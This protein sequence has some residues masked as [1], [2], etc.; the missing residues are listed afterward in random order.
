MNNKTFT[1]IS[2]SVIAVLLI[3]VLAVAMSS[4]L[5]A[6]Q[7]SVVSAATE[8]TLMYA[9]YNGTN[10][11]ITDDAAVDGHYTK[12]QLAA[13]LGLS[14]PN[15]LLAITSGQMLYDYLNNSG[16]YSSYQYA[17]LANDV[18][19]AF[20]NITKSGYDKVSAHSSGALFTKYLDGNGYKVSIEAGSGNGSYYT[21][22]ENPGNTN[23]DDSRSGTYA[24]T[25]YLCAVNQGTIKNLTID[26]TSNHIIT[27]SASNPNALYVP[28]NAKVV[29]GAGV[30][31]GL[32]KGTIDNIRLN[33]NSVF[34]LYMKPGGDR[35]LFENTS[36]IGGFAG[37]MTAGIISNSQ[38]DIATDGGVSVFVEGQQTGLF[39]D[40]NTGSVAGG[41]IG[42]LQ[43]GDAKVE[44]CALT[45]S[46]RIYACSNTS[47]VTKMSFAA[48]AIATSNNIAGHVIFSGEIKESEASNYLEIQENGKVNEGQIKGI[49]SSWTGTREDNWGDN[50]KSV[51]GLLFDA[52]GKNVQS[53][54]VLYNLNL[55]TK[56]NGGT[57]YSTLDSSKDIDNWTEIYP[58]S[59]GGS[60]SVRYDD[61]T[62]L[63]DIRIEAVADGHDGEKEAI[64]DF[65]MSTTGT[66]YHK[67]FMPEGSTGKII[68]SGVFDKNGSLTNHINMD[69]DKPIYAEIYMLKSTDYGKFNYTFGTMG[70]ITYTDNGNYVN[71]KNTKGY[72][73][74]GGALSFPTANFV[75]GDKQPT[76][77]YTWEVYRDGY[78]TDIAQSY[79]PGTYSMRTAV[80]LGTNTYGYYSEADRMIAWQAK[81]DYTFTI[82]QGVFSY[83]EA[84][85]SSSTGWEKEF[86]FTLKM[87][88]ANDFDMMRYQQNGV[89]ASEQIEVPDTDNSATF[90]T[91]QG[92]GKNGMQY[93]FYAYKFDEILQD[94]VVV[95]VSSSKTVKIDNEAPEIYDVR[96]FTE[97]AE[98]VRTEVTEAVLNSWQ[99]EKVIV[100]FT[101]TENGKSGLQTVASDG[102]TYISNEIVDE[103]NMY[104]VTLTL[105]DD[106]AHSLTY[107]DVVGNSTTFDIKAL[108]DLNAGSLDVRASGYSPYYG[109]YDPDGFNLMNSAQIGNSGWTLYVSDSVDG[110]GNPVWKEMGAVVNGDFINTVDW[111]IGDYDTYSPAD[112]RVK[113][114]ND[115]GLYEDVYAN[116]TAD[117]LVGQFCVY[118]KM[119]DFYV[120]VSLEAITDKDGNSLKDI[121]A[122]DPD[123]FNKVYDSTQ[124]YKGPELEIDISKS[125]VIM[126]NTDAYN[127]T[128]VIPEFSAIKLVLEYE[129]ASIGSTNIRM[130]AVLEGDDDYKFDVWFA[131]LSGDYQKNAEA[132]NKVAANITKLSVT[133]NLE[134]YLNAQYFY[135]DDIPAY[136]DANITADEVARIDLTTNAKKGASVGTYAVEGKLHTANDSIDVTI[137]KSSIQIVPLPVFVDLRYDGST[138][139]PT[140]IQFDGLTHEITATYKDAITGETKKATVDYTFVEDDK[141][142]SGFTKIGKFN[143]KISTGDGNYVVDGMDTFEMTVTKGFVNIEMKVVN[144]D[145][146]GNNNT[147]DLGLTEEQKKYFAEGDITINYYKYNDGAYYDSVEKVM[148]GSYDLNPTT[149]TSQRGYY[150][151]EVVVR[152]NDYFLGQTYGKDAGEL[153]LIIVNIAKT[154]ITGE[155]V[156]YNYDEQKHT[157]DVVKGKIEVKATAD[158]SVLW[159]SSMS[160]EGAIVVKYYDDATKSYVEVDKSEDKL[161]GWF[162]DVNE[163]GY[164]FRVE[165]VGTENYAS[166]SIDVTMVIDKAAFQNVT[167]AGVSGVY[168][169]QAYKITEV[170]PD[171]YKTSSTISYY[172]N[173]RAYNSLDDI[174]ALGACVNVGNYKIT[175]RMSK[176]NYVP[177][178]IEATVSIA[179]AKLN[180]SANALVATYDGTAHYL[181][182]NG[183]EFRDGNYYYMDHGKEVNALI[184]GTVSATDAGVYGGNITVFVNN[185]EAFDLQ[186]YIEIYPMALTA[187]SASI[188]LPNK[189]PSGVSVSN[190]YG[191]YTIDGVEKT[192]DLLYYTKSAETGNLTLVKPDKDGVLPDGVY[193]VYIEVDNNHYLQNTWELKVGQINDR[194]IDLVGWIV[195]GV[196]GA[197]MIA[198]I[199]TSIVT[200]KRRKQ[201]GTV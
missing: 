162:M 51:K 15:S 53:C 91:R 2:I 131:D 35:T 118:M 78:A 129:R 25:G 69:V 86:K 173:G 1:K 67:Y 195:I 75:G 114:V 115:E 109:T 57:E 166:C 135:G 185:Y 24:Y 171:E 178:N 88:R 56:S 193:T 128:T 18:A 11:Q 137:N 43:K 101:V 187:D 26:F 81:T 8:E 90:I 9:S 87:D 168:N 32:N 41:M 127:A 42:K 82:T 150:K 161:G 103:R 48:G 27:Q 49:I 163:K 164:S 92:T 74:V 95:A 7:M 55:L 106:K 21:T 112:L 152:E 176:D 68:W 17:F 186:T 117:G 177:L 70:N 139:I 169:A 10:G 189:L 196:V 126:E 60:M 174:Y 104:N 16:S 133:V 52:V 124:A 62:V 200:V 121:L 59:T 181:T 138:N 151:V 50:Y 36:Y 149:N 119:A 58:S 111:N 77:D 136:V 31:T 159:D 140:K 134:D 28:Q 23:K 194:N 158:K 198:A 113:M 64:S 165:Y 184:S 97:N 61:S 54:A 47:D 22:T 79:M 191:T 12:S 30:V 141:V 157:Y 19:I 125:G 76:E 190:Y 107:T 93:T 40:F 46:G 170:I 98:G 116:G 65:D 110:D 123:Y 45:G 180:I 142:M 89:F 37:V 144:V 192:G 14:D 38:V 182:F 145:Y 6:E 3:A 5:G 154:E 71:G 160:T 34:S 167:F 44:Y 132:I 29:A 96:Y 72:E 172:Y 108:V 153:G 105:T 83:D 155:S 94:Y 99:K 33:L 102:N 201:R 122:G 100:T 148:V 120:D 156:V 13:Q 197:L 4:A 175:L 146:T 183:L 84:N 179:N 143:Y 130:W 66:A 188:T 20:S 85:T 63:Y 199:I 39:D 80:K 147:Y 73:G